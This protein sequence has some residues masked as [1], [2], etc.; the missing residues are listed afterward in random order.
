MEIK[1]LIAFARSKTKVPVQNDEELTQLIE[2]L[3]KKNIKSLLEV[4]SAE[5][6]TMY[7]LAMALGLDRVTS[8]DFGEEHTKDTFEWFATLLKNNGI[9]AN[10][11]KGNSH[12]LSIIALSRRF[13]QHDAVLID[14]GHTYDDVLTDYLFYAK[15]AKKMVIFHDVD[16]QEVK[17]AIDAIIDID[18]LFLSTEAKYISRDVGMGFFVMEWNNA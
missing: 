2:H 15:M 17:R 4:G 14:A 9:E 1:E 3:S 16:M 8:I 6:M 5:G 11:I 13:G 10:Q 12:D 18:A 7:V